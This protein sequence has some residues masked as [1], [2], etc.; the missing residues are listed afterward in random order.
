ME[1]SIL[2]EA[3]KVCAFFFLA[4]DFYRNVVIEMNKKEKQKALMQFFGLTAK[5]AKNELIDC[6]EWN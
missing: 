6:G 5:Q 1:V 4:I 2:I 3:V